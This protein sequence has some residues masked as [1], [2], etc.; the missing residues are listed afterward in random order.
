MGKE[1]K[2]TSRRH[3]YGGQTDQGEAAGDVSAGRGDEVRSQCL[4]LPSH[5]DA[6][7]RSLPL[8]N[9]FRW[10]DLRHWSQ[11]KSVAVL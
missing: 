10:L 5:V 3:E 4:M 2:P 1:T 8:F 7:L 9:V 6:Y 11:L